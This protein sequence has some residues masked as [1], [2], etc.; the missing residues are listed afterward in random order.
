MYYP[1]L[2]LG[3]T[4]HHAL[5]LGLACQ[6]LP[7]PDT[8]LL[9]AWSRVVVCI[10]DEVGMLKDRLFLAIC[11]RLNSFRHSAT[12][13]FGDFN[14]LF[15][16]DFFQ[17]VIGKPFWS[18]PHTLSAA[19]AQG[20]PQAQQTSSD[21]WRRCLTHFYECIHNYR[22][23]QDPEWAALLGRLRYGAATQADIEFINSL[24]ERR[25]SITPGL[26]RILCFRNENREL[27]N[28]IV[29]AQVIRSLDLVAPGA[30]ESRNR[31]ALLSLSWKQRGTI[32]IK[33]AVLEPRTSQRVGNSALVEHV[34]GL[35]DHKPGGKVMAGVLD[36]T[37]GCPVLVTNSHQASTSSLGVSNG[38]LCTVE[39]V[40]LR[41]EAIVRLEQLSA[42]NPDLFIHTVFADEVEGVVLRQ[43][44]P[45]LASRATRNFPSLPT[46]CFPLRPQR[47]SFSFTYNGNQRSVGMLQ[48]A[49][50]QAFATTGHSTQGSTLSRATVWE[51]N[52]SLTGYDYTLLSRVGSSRQLDVLARFPEGVRHNVPRP[53]MHEMNRLRASVGLELEPVPEPPQGRN[54]SRS[55]GGRS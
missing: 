5:A 4:I 9:Q 34:L 12:G 7:L 31:G 48:L 15:L 53:A 26:S 41:P 28:R 10:V 47:I 36:L 1:V 52:P 45:E 33:A 6:L 43:V 11:E 18:P 54:S 19:Q 40:L 8:S 17:L 27:A 30:P 22:A 35:A 29:S 3:Y 44:I 38:T 21:L 24:A 49:L 25:T 55:R 51:W 37:L 13:L 2:S 46:G 23:Q 50:V 14:M 16:G 42:T 32:R 39:D 20:I